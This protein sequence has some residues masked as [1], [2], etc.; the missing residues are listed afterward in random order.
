[1]QTLAK[2]RATGLVWLHPTTAQMFLEGDLTDFSCPSARCFHGLSPRREE[3]GLPW[4]AHHDLTKS[5][6]KQSICV[7]IFAG[8]KGGTAARE[9]V[10]VQVTVSG[11]TYFLAENTYNY[12]TAN[13][14]LKIVAPNICPVKCHC[15]TSTHLCFL[16][17]WHTAERQRSDMVFPQLHFSSST[18]LKSPLYFLDG[19]QSLHL[20]MDFGLYRNPSSPSPPVRTYK[21]KRPQ[22]KANPCSAAQI[23]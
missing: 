3:H 10:L 6:Q 14:K 12:Q 13:R 5:K 9:V 18:V 17:T 22:T 7:E 19:F 23:T 21:K 15:D 1:M 8:G 2:L 11:D 4:A 20:Q 16:P